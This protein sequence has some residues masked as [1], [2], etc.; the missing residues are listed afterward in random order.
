MTNKLT[1]E[2]K[3][4]ASYTF[5]ISYSHL[6]DQES[7]IIKQL[8]DNA[9]NRARQ[10]SFPLQKDRP[11]LFF[12]KDRST[13][14]IDKIY[15]EIKEK[16]SKSCAL[17]A[18]VSPNYLK[19]AWCFLEWYFFY[20]KTPQNDTSSRL[21][22]KRFY[23]ID[24]ESIPNEFFTIESLYE[25]IDSEVPYS[26]HNW[27][28]VHRILQSEH[29]GGDPNE[30]VKEWVNFFSPRRS[31]DSISANYVQIEDGKLFDAKKSSLQTTA[32]DVFR[33]E[34]FV[35]LRDAIGR[36]KIKKGNYDFHGFDVIYAS[37]KPYGHEVLSHIRSISEDYVGKL[38][39]DYKPICVIYTGGTIGGRMVSRSDDMTYHTAEAMA[40]AESA[41]ELAEYLGKYSYS[42]RNFDF[43]VCFMSIGKPSDSADVEPRDW[44]KFAEVVTKLSDLYQGFVILHGTN[45]LTYTAAALSYLLPTLDKPVVLTASESPIMQESD[46]LPNILHSIRV[47]AIESPSCRMR[48]IEIRDVPLSVGEVFIYFG[49]KLLRGNCT[50]R[51][52]AEGEH[53]YKMHNINELGKQKDDYFK[54]TYEKVINYK[55]YSEEW[56]ENLEE[57]KLSL[58]YEKYLT[59]NIN[60]ISIY[61]GMEAVWDR[62]P[63]N[64]HAFIF[65]GYTIGNLSTQATKW[66]EDTVSEKRALIAIA[67]QC[68]EGAPDLRGYEMNEKTRHCINCGAMTL[69]SSYAK[70]KWLIAVC[71]VNNNFER[72]NAHNYDIIEKYVKDGFEHSIRGEY[73]DVRPPKQHSNN[74]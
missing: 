69:E 38:T 26:E 21:Q 31:I 64:Y 30:I 27:Q 18:F 45:T 12:D 54:L 9:I 7:G 15:S 2:P 48:I 8:Y 42:F 24:I 57:E 67:S 63:E 41:E 20:Y 6:D 51:F 36:G 50:F 29:I 53:S 56:S 37:H 23:R 10:L 46:A 65:R 40:T 43:D 44:I 4:Y 74:N 25:L 71:M 14:D 49:R 34:I 58:Y 52:E 22:D 28:E 3:A 70:L 62:Q 11:L 66:I 19:S 73:G 35:E 33:N 17:F 55:T 59:V 47:A 72:I 68:F 61:P 1:R 5:F 13:I 32:L 39:S 16:C 60:I